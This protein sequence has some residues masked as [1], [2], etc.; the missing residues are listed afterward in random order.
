MSKF[1]FVSLFVFRN[2]CFQWPS[3]ASALCFVL[4]EPMVELKNVSPKYFSVVLNSGIHVTLLCSMF[5][6]SACLKNM[7]DFF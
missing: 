1:E 2:V 6:Y 7:N 5:V 3:S 4:T